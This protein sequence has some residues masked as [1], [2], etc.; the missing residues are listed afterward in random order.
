[1]TYYGVP[2]NPVGSFVIYYDGFVIGY[3]SYKP[4]NMD[5]RTQANSNTLGV[6]LTM[7]CKP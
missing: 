4:W 5:E 1:M 2:I 3:W 7:L 6:I